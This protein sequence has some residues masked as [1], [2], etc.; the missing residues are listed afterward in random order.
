MMITMCDKIQ[1]MPMS[2][3][4]SFYFPLSSPHNVFFSSGTRKYAKSSLAAVPVGVAQITKNI[5]I[6]EKMAM[7]AF[8][9]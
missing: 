5:I 7:F 4:V 2:Y 8:A 1:K 9:S 6:H 3:G